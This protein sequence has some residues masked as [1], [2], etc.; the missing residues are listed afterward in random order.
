MF[1]WSPAPAAPGQR[2]QRRQP[3]QLVFDEDA[4]AVNWF[5]T[6]STFTVLVICLNFLSLYA[7]TQA[8]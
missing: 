7:A 3:V 1:D 5:N 8:S 4:M 6:D 2:S